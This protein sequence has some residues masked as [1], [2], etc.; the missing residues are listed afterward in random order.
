M[1]YIGNKENILDKIHSILIEHGVSGNSFF[2][3]FSGT[4]NVA[5]YYKKLGYKI[6]SSDVMYMSFCLQKAY[7]ENGEEPAFRELL[8]QININSAKFFASSL[9]LILEYLDSIPDVK[10]FIFNNY[11]PEGTKDLA[12]PRMYFSNENGM[13]IDAIRQQ[14]ELWHTKNLI[15]DSEYYILLACL[16]ETISFYANVAGVYAAFHKKWDPRA[17]KRLAMRSIEII[18][19]STKNY[20]HYGDSLDLVDD[21]K[22]DILYLDPPYNE[23]QYLPNYHI[24]ETIAAY[25]NPEIRGVTG[26]RGYDNKKSTFCNA[27]TALRD[28]E[29]VAKNAKYKYLVLSYNTE[30]IMPQCEIINTLSKYGEVILEEFQ[31]LRF[32]SNN[33]GLAKTKKHIN[34]Q[35]YILKRNEQ[36]K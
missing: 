32:K 36:G 33:N 31:Y 29:L 20:V 17:V 21:Y 8:P 13:R 4:T 3:F 14:I 7:I 27:K 11:T 30:G 24:V 26:M 9:E 5:R 28:L 19:N 1:R 15:T 10:G 23:R 18:P 25:D 35:L 6:Y 16:I 12:R 22:V 34:E 2:D